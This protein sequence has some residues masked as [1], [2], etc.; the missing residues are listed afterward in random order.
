MSTPISIDI[1]HK[2][3][4]AEARS[5]MDKGVDRIGDHVPGGGKVQHHWE[6]DRL[7]FTVTAIGQTIACRCDVMEDKVHADIDLPPV[8]S[9]FAG[10]IR[11]VFGSALPKLL[12]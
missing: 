3:G 8:L 2:L 1:P 6:G 5:R 7:H 11:G 12:K 4:K 10:K 9:L